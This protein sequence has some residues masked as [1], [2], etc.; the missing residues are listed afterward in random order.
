MTD[1]RIR[2]TVLMAAL[3]VGVLAC[4]E[5]DGRV[6]GCNEECGIDNDTGGQMICARGLTCMSG[7]CRNPDCPEEIDC[8]CS[9]PPEGTRTP[10]PIPTPP[11]TA[12]PTPLPPP[13]VVDELA[14]VMLGEYQVTTEV[15][16]DTQGHDNRDPTQGPCYI[17]MP[18]SLQWV[19]APG[20]MTQTLVVDGSEP[21][22]PLSGTMG[23]DG[24]FYGDGTWDVAG[25][26]GIT[27]RLEG[28][29]E[30][31]E[32]E[33]YYGF[34]GILHVGAE[35]GLPGGVGTLYGITANQ[36]TAAM[37]STATVIMES[38]EAFTLELSEAL[39]TGNTE[40]LLDHLYPQLVGIYGTGQC[41][42]Y[43][44]RITN[45][46]YQIETHSVRQIGPWIW[47]DHGVSLHVPDTLEVELSIAV[48][49]QVT[50]TTAHYASDGEGGW[51]WFTFCGIPLP[52]YGT[53]ATV[54]DDDY[55]VCGPGCRREEGIIEGQKHIVQCLDRA[56]A[57]AANA[58]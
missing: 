46:A 8:E 54:L 48:G 11:P 24:S 15:F 51:Y 12:T 47:Q 36:I 14:P 13:S 53:T 55:T 43:L 22:E 4:G 49:D 27:V 7:V 29:F 18:E 9:P 56:G 32:L 44:S 45:P 21:W 39:Q 3:L 19:V 41:R 30:L 34:N 35:G 16:T 2:R 25:F 58:T 1:K 38:V 10:T 31:Y 17:C 37:E 42:D 50:E 6:S 52:F 23:L 28:E 33:G 20:S 5:P 57:C 26:S 40:Y